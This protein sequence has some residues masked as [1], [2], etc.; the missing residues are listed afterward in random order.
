MQS[1]G[2]F[3]DSRRLDIEASML[4]PLDEQLRLNYLRTHLAA[5][6][7]AKAGGVAE[8]MSPLP[9]A[10]MR[11]KPAKSATGQTD[12]GDRGTPPDMLRDRRLLIEN[13]ISPPSD[14]QS[15]VHQSSLGGQVAGLCLVLANALSGMNLAT[16]KGKTARPSLNIIAFVIEQY[17]R[18][19]Y[20]GK[21]GRPR[22]KALRLPASD[23]QQVKETWRKFR[24]VAALWATVVRTNEG[25]RITPLSS[26]FLAE[27]C[28]DQFFN[29]AGGYELARQNFFVDRRPDD[30]PARARANASLEQHSLNP[31]A[32]FWMDLL[33]EFVPK[34][35]VVK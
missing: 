8:A 32:Q 17:Y 7:I 20:G 25:S 11:G 34:Y 19:N 27:T 21:R 30:H 15:S 24:S 28:W 29:V 22:A 6:A 10:M 2:T 5:L 33:R 3:D 14:P 35:S 26:N 31:E 23:A 9:A 13:L 1:N 18:R 4:F 16:A 12:D